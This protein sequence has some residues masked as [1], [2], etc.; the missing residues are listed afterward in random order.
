MQCRHGGHVLG[1]IQGLHDWT[2]FHRLTAVLTPKPVKYQTEYVSKNIIHTSSC[3]SP[4]IDILGPVLEST[5]NHFRSSLKDLS[6]YF[7]KKC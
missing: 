5:G 6:G 4:P 3:V 1:V 2:G 7:R